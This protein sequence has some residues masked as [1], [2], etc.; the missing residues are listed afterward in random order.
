MDD[1]ARCRISQNACLQAWPEIRL[2]NV[3]PG[4]PSWVFG[5]KLK[6]FSSCK[7][8]WLEAV[9]LKKVGDFYDAM[10]RLYILK[11]GYNLAWLADLEEDIKDPEDVDISEVA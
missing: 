7:D 2:I 11:C 8:Q 9:E 10:T 3:A 6:F 1:C 4:K 5:T